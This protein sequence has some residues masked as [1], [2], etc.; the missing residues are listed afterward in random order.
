MELLLTI[1]QTLAGTPSHLRGYSDT[2]D[3]WQPPAVI[4]PL[5]LAVSY[6]NSS[7]LVIQ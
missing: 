6:G 5:V 3:P 7:S 1:A 4:T 2:Q